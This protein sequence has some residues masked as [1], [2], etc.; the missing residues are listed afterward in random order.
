[1][2]TIGFF[3]SVH[4]DH[5][6]SVGGLADVPPVPHSDCECNEDWTKS[7]AGHLDILDIFIFAVRL[8]SLNRQ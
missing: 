5:V 7:S 2:I 3:I 1:M 6:V 8:S 4:A